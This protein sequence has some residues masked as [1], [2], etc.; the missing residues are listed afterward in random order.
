MM[1][2]RC[3][4]GLVR[5]RS[6]IWRRG[7]ISNQTKQGWIEFGGIIQEA[8]VGV[9]EFSLYIGE[10]EAACKKAFDSAQVP[11]DRR[12]AM[13]RDII[14]SGIMPDFF[15]EVVDSILGAP[16]RRLKEQVSDLVAIFHAEDYWQW[17]SDDQRSENN[18][19]ADPY[20]IDVIKKTSLTGV[21]HQ[22]RR[23]TRCGS[24]TEIVPGNATQGKSATNQYL[25][26]I[27]K[28][29]VC[30]GAWVVVDVDQ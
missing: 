9:K 5:L 4:H 8:P 24:C 28:T 26:Y 2:H 20:W 15:G 27:S 30:G 14:I 19:L 6:D 18:D 25:N 1:I 23:C 29:C 12:T 17:H 13:E 16:L 21:R 7:G 11:D 10:T 22:M 3:F